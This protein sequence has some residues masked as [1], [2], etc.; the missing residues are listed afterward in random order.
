MPLFNC[1]VQICV[2]RPFILLEQRAS[3][4]A[5]GRFSS[6][7]GCVILGKMDLQ[8]TARLKNSCIVNCLAIFDCN[9]SSCAL[10]S[11]IMSDQ[12]VARRNP[13]SNTLKKY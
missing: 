11:T 6:R 3:A 5:G 13:D 9:S 8:C 12:D 10:F 1:I 7:M 2:D 4:N